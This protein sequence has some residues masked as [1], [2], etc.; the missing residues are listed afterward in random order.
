MLVIIKSAHDTPEAK[1]AVKLARDLAADIVLLQNAVCLAEKDRLESF[2]G[3]AHV[4]EED[5]KL[6]GIDDIDKGVRPIDYDQ[7]V[8]LISENDK[9]IGMF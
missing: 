6:R 9:A 7:L 8:E 5:L 2:C 1:R 3:T 4:I